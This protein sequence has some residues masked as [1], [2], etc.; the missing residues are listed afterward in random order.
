MS[1]KLF[2][3]SEFSS[4][5]SVDTSPTDLNFNING[6]LSDNYDVYKVTLL[7]VSAPNIEKTFQT[8]INTSLVFRENSGVVDFTATIPQGTFN[9]TDLAT[10]IA[11][12][13]NSVVGIAN[14]YSCEYNQSTLKFMISAN[15]P[16][17]FQ[18]RSN[19]N[20]LSELGYLSTGT[21]GFSV[22]HTSPNIVNLIG[23]RYMDITINHPT[24]SIA[25]G[26]TQRSNILARCAWSVPKGAIEKWEIQ[27]PLS[28]NVSRNSLSS[29]EIIF[30]NSYGRKMA[31]DPNHR[32]CLTLQI[33]P[34]E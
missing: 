21:S 6:L 16:N 5:K 9:G 34:V 20:C 13:M 17:T 3:D 23:S 7:E 18:I 19:S 32:I 31:F 29:I 1:I 22:S 28:H 26:I 25:T 10:Q 12:S 30:Y 27:N 8:G 15:I 11:A 2:L 33:Q 14:S 24:N 4:Y